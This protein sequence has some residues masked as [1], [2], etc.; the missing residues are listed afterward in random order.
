M[1][2]EESVALGKSYGRSNLNEAEKIE[3]DRRSDLI[4]DLKSRLALTKDVHEMAK[5]IEEIKRVK[6]ST[7]VKSPFIGDCTIPEV[8]PDTPQIKKEPEV[9]F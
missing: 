3:V 7:L 2:W 1:K 9:S 4:N 5:I 6:L 8:V